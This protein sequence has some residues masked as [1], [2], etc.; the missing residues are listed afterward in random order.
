M[1][2]TKA[3]LRRPVEDHAQ[4]PAAIRAGL[5]TSAMRRG[6]ANVDMGQLVI[7]HREGCGRTGVELFRG[8]VRRGRPADLRCARRG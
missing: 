4:R 1:V 7:R 2:E 6:F 5:S 8:R 3:P